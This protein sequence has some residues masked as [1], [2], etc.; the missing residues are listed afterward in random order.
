MRGDT[1]K[2]L[3]VIVC[4]IVLTGILIL[5]GCAN[6]DSKKRTLKIAGSTTVQPIVSKVAEEYM[7]KNPDV[8][9][10]VQ[11]GG[12]GTGIRMVAEGSVD[13]GDASR[14]IKQSEYDKTPDLEPYAIAVDGIAVVVHPS[15]PLVDLTK[16]QIKKIFAGEISNFKEFGGHDKEIVVV[17][18]ESGSGTRATFE[19]LVMDG[20]EP[21]SDAL[22]KPSNGAVKATVSGNPNAIG[23]I[24]VGYIDNS[25]KALKIDGVSPSRDTIKNGSYPIFRRLYL[26]TK[27]DATGLTRDFI[28]FV[29]SDE[30]Q[31]IVEEK[32]FVSVR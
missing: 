11:G 23:Y 13:I 4:F 28:D 6:N 25:V 32:G 3:G 12:S 15:N 9:I 14:E 10:S 27:G 20:K 1:G 5:S 30:G 17:I 7:E 18:R 24:G 26:I 16:E 19:E 8:F 31:K 21:V 2:I 29:L 22:Q